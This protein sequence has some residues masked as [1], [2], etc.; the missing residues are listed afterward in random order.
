MYQLVNCQGRLMKC[1]KELCNESASHSQGVSILLVSSDPQKAWKLWKLGYILA[2]FGYELESRNNFLGLVC[3][4][5][6]QFRS[7]WQLKQ[8]FSPLFQGGWECTVRRNMLGKQ[9]Q[10]VNHIVRLMKEVSQFGGGRNKKVS[11]IEWDT[12]HINYDQFS[13][14]QGCT[15]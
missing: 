15:N 8:L 9:Q 5:N 13:A 6:Q 7:L 11:L 1:F 2:I 4:Q 10:F 14:A 12:R 3:Q